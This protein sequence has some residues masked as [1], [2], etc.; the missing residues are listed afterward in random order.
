MFGAR[1][2][3]GTGAQ[4]KMSCVLEVMLRRLSSPAVAVL[5][6]RL[7]KPCRGLLLLTAPHTDWI[8]RRQCTLRH[9]Q[10]HPH[11]QCAGITSQAIGG[12][13]DPPRKCKSSFATS[14]S[15]IS[16]DS[17]LIIEPT[18]SVV[19]CARLERIKSSPARVFNLLLRCC[20]CFNSLVLTPSPACARYGCYRK[21]QC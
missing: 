5:P 16:I 11:V 21:L 4:K 17:S 2:P 3:P 7:A 20:C 6:D 14:I 19:C 12:R 9:A 10:P 15:L 1:V 13:R 8:I 18:P